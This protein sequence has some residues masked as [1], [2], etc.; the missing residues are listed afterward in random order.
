MVCFHTGRLGEWYSRKSTGGEESFEGDSNLL[1]L[2]WA[3][4]L[5]RL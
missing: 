2:I 1:P 5:T 4:L 3:G